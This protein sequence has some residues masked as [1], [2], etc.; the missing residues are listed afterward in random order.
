MKNMGD[1]HDHYLKKDVL[2]LADVFE[3]FID[4]FL[5]LY[6]LYHCHY[7]LFKFSWTELGCDVKDDWCR[8]RKNI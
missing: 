6:R 5:K 3:K 7:S 1:Y 2:L 8:V 4:M